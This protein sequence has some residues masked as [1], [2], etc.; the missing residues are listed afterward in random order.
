MKVNPKNRLLLI[1]A[2]I[3][4]GVCANSWAAAQVDV[5]IIGGPNLIVD[6]NALSPSTYAPTT[7]TVAVKY[8]NNTAAPIDDIYAHIGNIDGGGGG[9]DA[10]DLSGA[11]Q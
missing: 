8:C 6:S 7:F 2:Q 11:R 10:R 1:T 4:F 3:A 5:E 9:G